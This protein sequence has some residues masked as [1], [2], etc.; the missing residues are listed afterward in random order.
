MVVHSFDCGFCLGRN[1]NSRL[2]HRR[3]LYNY[4]IHYQLHCDQHGAA[5][6]QRSVRAYFCSDFRGGGIGYGY[7]HLLLGCAYLWRHAPTKYCVR[8]CHC[9][10]RH[11]C[12][13]CGLSI[14]NLQCRCPKCWNPINRWWN[15]G[16]AI[17]RY[18]SLT[19]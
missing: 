15:L 1:P 19:Y 10:R 12:S 7:C 17:R 6:Y 13:P 9:G 14:P 3:N 16:L 18:S 8:W 2:D 4:N 5:K 11:D